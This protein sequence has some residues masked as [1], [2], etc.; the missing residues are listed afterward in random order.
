MKVCKRC[1]MEFD[2]DEDLYSGIVIKA[3]ESILI[4]LHILVTC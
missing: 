2:E 4:S 3:C 1:F